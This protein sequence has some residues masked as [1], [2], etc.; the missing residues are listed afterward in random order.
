VRANSRAKCDENKIVKLQHYHILPHTLSMLAAPVLY[1]YM[2]LT[3]HC[4]S[5]A[6]ETHDIHDEASARHKAVEQTKMYRHNVTTPLLLVLIERSRE[7]IG[8]F[9]HSFNQ[10]CP[11]AEV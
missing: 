9:I 4:A 6:V 8:P 3:H 10:V 2:E 1:G 7:V 11:A 5:I